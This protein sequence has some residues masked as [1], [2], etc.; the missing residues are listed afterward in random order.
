MAN[1][2]VELNHEGI[3]DMLRS[4]EAKAICEKQAKDVQS[5][6]GEGYVVSSYTGEGRVNASVLA[7]SDKAKRDNMK[8]N[9]ILKAMRGEG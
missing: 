9:T 7:E 1:L 5:R 3:R 8:N 2:K 4:P 6:L